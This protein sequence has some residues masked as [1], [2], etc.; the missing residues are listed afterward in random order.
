MLATVILYKVQCVGGTPYLNCN[1]G[2]RNVTT[3]V[4]EIIFSLHI[5][6][7]VFYLTTM[8]LKQVNPVYTH[9]HF[10]RVC[11]FK[12][13]SGKKDIQH[14]LKTKIQCQEISDW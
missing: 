9:T 2:P 5:P 12:K 4:E 10:L 14:H 3:L 11:D 13:S 8:K 6:R 1:P 7:V